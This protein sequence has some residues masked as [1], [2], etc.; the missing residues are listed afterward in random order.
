MHQRNLRYYDYDGH[1]IPHTPGLAHLF[2][3]FL[4]LSLHL[5]AVSPELFSL[6][7]GQVPERILSLLH[8]PLKLTLFSPLVWLS[9][10]ISDSRV[11]ASGTHLTLFPG[12]RK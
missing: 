2:W 6:T 9:G 5:L 1:L 8:P 4:G 11:G 7:R 10:P 3:E 12:V